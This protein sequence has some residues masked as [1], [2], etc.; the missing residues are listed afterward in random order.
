MRKAEI[1]GLLREMPEE[2]DVEDLIH[3]IFLLKKLER[4][5]QAVASGQVLA[6]DEVVKKSAGWRR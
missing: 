4:A 2:L 3:R 1:L 5:E 6:H